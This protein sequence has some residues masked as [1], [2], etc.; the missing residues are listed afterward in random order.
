SSNGVKITYGG[1]GTLTLT[2]IAKGANTVY[3]QHNVSL[4]S[5]SAGVPLILR[6][7]V[8]CS[9]TP[10]QGWPLIAVVDDTGKQKA[11]SSTTSGTYTLQFTLPADWFMIRFQG[12]DVVDSTTVFSNVGVYRLDDWTAMQKHGITWFN[13]TDYPLF[14][15]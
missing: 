2:G 1:D 11:A 15:Q 5:R 10:Y 14:K 7:T 4:N 8:V 9:H 13:S 6:A 12:S 3:Y